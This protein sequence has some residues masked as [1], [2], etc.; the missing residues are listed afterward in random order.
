MR[1]E[2]KMISIIVPVYNVERYLDECI[3]SILNQTYKNYELI[4]VDDGSTDE[5]GTKCDE[6]AQLDKRVKVIHK[7]NGGPSEAR[8]I[9]VS[10]AKYD[11]ITFIDS[12]DYVNATYLSKLVDGINK[13]GAD[14]CAVLMLEVNEGEIIKKREKDYGY[15]VVQ[16]TGEEALLNIL[17]Q[18]DLDT[19]PCGMLFRREIVDANPFPVGRFHEDDFTMYKFF[20][21]AKVVTI[22]K[23]VEYYYVQHSSSI[24]HN[25]SIVVLND[26]VEASDNLDNYFR[27]SCPEKYIAAKSKKFSNYCQILIK[28]PHLSTENKELY[29][30]ILA[31]LKKER[32]N[33][34][35]NRHTRFKNKIAAMLLCFGIGAFQ[36][37]GKIA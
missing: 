16:I 2:A 13:Y 28:Y 15:K 37:A 31:F 26:E 7:E 29:D 36:L 35:F 18:K 8:N 10:Q 11:Y 34:I 22:V 3:Q 23:S 4:L 30:K 33:I 32:I 6:Y 19:T 5:S 27:D 1:K 17:Y 9:A 14:I 12:D 24:M 25:Q 21:M 20:E